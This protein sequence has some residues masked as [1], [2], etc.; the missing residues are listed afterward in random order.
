MNSLYG[1]EDVIG[2]KDGSGYD[3][4][5]DI[6]SPMDFSDIESKLPSEISGVYENRSYKFQ[7]SSTSYIQIPNIPMAY[8]FT[9]VSF[10]RPEK[11]GPLF[12]WDPSG[13]KGDHLRVNK[14][15]SS[16]SLYF[17]PSG[18]HAITIGK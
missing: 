14:I 4:I 17:A 6:N 8:D 7:G 10:V 9:I 2:G 11:D 16:Y 1:F 5:L 18:G 12:A 15:G 13:Q 3:V